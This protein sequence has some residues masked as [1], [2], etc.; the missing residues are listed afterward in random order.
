MQI[1]TESNAS[2]KTKLV[3]FLQV[4]GRHELV[5]SIKNHSVAFDFNRGELYSGGNN[6]KVSFNGGLAK[7]W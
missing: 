1:L 3:E 6:T 2:L 4:L 7:Y 5:D